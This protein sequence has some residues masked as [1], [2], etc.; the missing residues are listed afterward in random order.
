MARDVET[1]RRTAPAKCA[2]CDR[3][4]DSPLFC[5]SCR[6]LYPAEGLSFFDL[7]GL[8]PGYDLDLTELRRKYFAVVR[9]IHP[10]RMIAA[11][12][13]AQR[14]CMRTSA[15]INQA[16][17]VL[18]DPLLRAEYLL[19]LAGGKA[20]TDDKQVPQSVLSE[21]LMLRE[22]IEEAK[23]A[24]DRRALDGVRRQVQARFDT[25]REEIASLA[26]QLPSTQE[27]RQ[28]LRGKLNAIRYY[29]RLLEQF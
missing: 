28:D 21:A 29:R 11:D 12:P 20:A 7:L 27:S 2:A 10:D 16:F 19:E 15:L 1:A 6:R 22:E 9:D 13:A 26:Q 23:A 24:D 14:L 25:T 18:R 4:L 17:E 8:R 3:P 5:S